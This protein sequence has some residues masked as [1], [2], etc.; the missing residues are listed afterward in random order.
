MEGRVGR[1]GGVWRV[2]R[3]DGVW[4]GGGRKDGVEG[5]GE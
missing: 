1:K 3:K 5:R 4:R 2:G